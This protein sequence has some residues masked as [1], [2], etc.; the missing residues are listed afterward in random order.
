[1]RILAIF[2][3]LTAIAAYAVTPD[4]QWWDINPTNTIAQVAEGAG[5]ATKA[6]VS[7]EVAHAEAS[8]LTNGWRYAMF[9]LPMNDVDSSPVWTEFEMK[10][11]T[12]NFDNGNIVMHAMSSFSDLTAANGHALTDQYQADAVRIYVQNIP[13]YAFQV[14]NS[15]DNRAYHRIASTLDMPPEW[16]VREY[17]V[18]VDPAMLHYVPP[19]PDGSSWCDRE[20][21]DLVWIYFRAGSYD[22]ETDQDGKTL[23][24]PVSP[25]RWFKELPEWADKEPLRPVQ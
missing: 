17:A 20:N 21:R 1:M 14:T 3:A 11:T 16:R 9:I 6:F 18:I 23:F 7:N 15:V 22:A 4:T 2:T 8:S 10:A 19:A 25:V 24:H 5:L 13:S 12:N